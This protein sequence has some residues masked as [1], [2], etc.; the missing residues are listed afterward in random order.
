MAENPNAIKN[1]AIIGSGTLGTQISLI[2]V[3]NGYKVTNFDSKKDA[4]VRSIERLQS[5]FKSKN[6]EPL[7]PY[8]ESRERGKHLAHREQIQSPSYN[9][10]SPGRRYP[11]RGRPYPGNSNRH[12]PG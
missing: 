5:E 10:L 2:S 9:L 3:Y 1:I 11:Y 8:R 7:I 4:F 6:I 12:Q